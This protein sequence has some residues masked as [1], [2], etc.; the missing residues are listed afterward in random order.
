[1]TE[2]S[3][4]FFFLKINYFKDVIF[5]KDSLLKHKAC[6]DQL[7]KHGSFFMGHTVLHLHFSSRAFR[8]TRGIVIQKFVC[9]SVRA[10]VRMMSQTC[11]RQNLRTVIGMDLLFF[12]MG[13]Y[14]SGVVQ[15]QTKLGLRMG[16][17]LRKI[18]FFR[19]FYKKIHNFP[20]KIDIDLI[21]FL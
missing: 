15:W 8:P 21:F 3:K 18:D 5:D 10:S 9:A 20:T 2:F 11:T 13:W 16:K 4:C 19:F 7:Y 17:A 1:M 14:K 12:L 6:K